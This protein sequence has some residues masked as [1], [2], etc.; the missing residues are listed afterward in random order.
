MTKYIISP[1]T[2]YNEETELYD[3]KI[4]VEGRNMPLH[5]T[6]HGKTESQSRERAQHLAKIITGD[7]PTLKETNY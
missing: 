1:I 7:I 2:T 6:A 5:Y 4:G 3:T